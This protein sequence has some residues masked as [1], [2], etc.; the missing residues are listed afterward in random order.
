M[1]LTPLW[2]V[3][4]RPNIPYW[5]SV[6]A[7]LTKRQIRFNV[8]HLSDEDCRDKV[9]DIYN[10]P[11]CCRVVRNYCLP[12]ER[13][14]RYRENGDK[15]RI[16]PL[17]YNGEARCSSV[18]KS[19]ASVP[20]TLPQEFIWSF[21]GTNWFGRDKMLQPLMDLQPYSLKYCK[22]FMD[23]NTITPAQ[24]YTDILCNSIFVPTP[25]GNNPETFRL[26]EALE[27]GRIPLYVRSDGDDDYWNWLKSW[28]T[29][30][31]E[32]P[33]WE[34]AKVVMIKL[35]ENPEHVEQY[36]SLLHSKWNEFKLKASCF[37]S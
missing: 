2:F 35:M 36:A 13:M 29:P 17:G 37:F 10:S 30:L 11:A 16:L 6:C 18:G 9:D 5:N 32:I 3:I 27:Y 7:E 21:H 31:L 12:D 20:L 19:S 33:T 22:Y 25:R 28:L 15:I 23:K 14:N 1:R 8:L 26:Y 4:A 34:M 24:E